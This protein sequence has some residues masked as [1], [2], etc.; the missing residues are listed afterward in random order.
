[1]NSNEVYEVQVLSDFPAPRSTG[2]CEAWAG[3]SDSGQLQWGECLPGTPPSTRRLCDEPPGPGHMESV[4]WKLLN[5]DEAMDT[6]HRNRMKIQCPL[7][8][9]DLLLRLPSSSLLVDPDEAKAEARISYAEDVVARACNSRNIGHRTEQ[10]VRLAQSCAVLRKLQDCLGT[11][12]SVTLK[13]LKAYP[14]MPG[15]GWWNLELDFCVAK[16]W[17]WRLLQS[18]TFFYHL[19][20]MWHH[21][22][23]YANKSCNLSKSQVFLHALA[24]LAA[25]LNCKLAKTH[26]NNSKHPLK[27]LS[28]K[29]TLLWRRR[30]NY[31][32]KPRELAGATDALAGDPVA[33]LW[34]FDGFG[35]KEWR[36]WRY[37]MIQLFSI[38]SMHC[39][40][41]PTAGQQDLQR[42]EGGWNSNFFGVC[43]KSWGLFSGARQLTVCTGVA[44]IPKHSSLGK[45]DTCDHWQR[46]KFTVKARKCGGTIL[47][48]GSVPWSRWQSGSADSRWDPAYYAGAQAVQSQGSVPWE[49]IHR[50]CF[51]S[52][53]SNFSAGTGTRFQRQ[54]VTSTSSQGRSI[55][56]YQRSCTWLDLQPL[57]CTCFEGGIKSF[58]TTPHQMMSASAR[59]GK[60]RLGR[61]A[62]G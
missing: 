37:H 31:N 4:R 48:W 9:G 44:G 6:G 26:P 5:W 58:T 1:M 36:W 53:H 61:F 62:F 2:R 30:G 15:D 42:L 45:M 10:S 34:D 57:L 47:R 38:F 43:H 24:G 51:S 28:Q 22:A 25:F 23:T 55:P 54:R 19:L 12:F 49:L 50:L 20:S 52:E 18:F 33:Q 3:K 60:F 13:D 46:C 29:R 39:S 8:P 11:H 32:T 21:T 14:L 17:P 41:P 35:A 27:I 7:A 59:P 40:I 56:Q 16:V